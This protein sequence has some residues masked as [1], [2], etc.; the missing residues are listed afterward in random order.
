MTTTINFELNGESVTVETPPDRS[1]REL[2]REEL[3][4]YEVKRGCRSGR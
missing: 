4:S 3:D 1:L 2:L